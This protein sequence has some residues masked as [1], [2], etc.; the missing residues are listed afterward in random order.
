MIDI[1]VVFDVVGIF[2]EICEYYWFCVGDIVFEFR[3]VLF[4]KSIFVVLSVVVWINNSLLFER[5]V[6]YY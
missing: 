5:V 4:L 2:F 3:V 1:D 6:E